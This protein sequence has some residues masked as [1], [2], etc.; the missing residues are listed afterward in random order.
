M[1][2]WRMKAADHLAVLD[3]FAADDPRLGAV[4]K[5]WML[6]P[7]G[8]S[9]PFDPTAWY[10]LGTLVRKAERGVDVWHWGSW[11]YTPDKG[12]KG[13]VR[14]SFVA[15]ANRLADGTAWFVYAEPRVEEGS[16]RTELSEALLNAYRSVKKWE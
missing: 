10:G 14:T 1:G 15:H 5:A 6:D 16:P 7:A 13:T 3:L 11:D 2:G 9:V 4:A 12:E 8:K